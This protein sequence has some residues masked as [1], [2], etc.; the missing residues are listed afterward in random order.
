[1]YSRQ[2]AC[3]QHEVNPPPSLNRKTSAFISSLITFRCLLQTFGLHNYLS[4]F[5]LAFR[6]PRRRPTPALFC[7]RC[8]FSEP[9]YLCVG[10]C[11]Y[12]TDCSRSHC[13]H[14]SASIVPDL[15]VAFPPETCLFSYLFCGYEH[16]RSRCW[17]E[18]LRRFPLEQR[19]CLAVKLTLQQ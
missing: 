19:P 11:A 14:T 4:K 17:V 10:V 18:Q 7:N 2:N 12:S 16:V 1:M 8:Y 9:A 15:L 13:I 3:L 5:V 6:Q